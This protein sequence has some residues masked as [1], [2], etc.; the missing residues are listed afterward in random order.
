MEVVLLVII[1]AIAIYLVWPDSMVDDVQPEETQVEYPMEDAFGKMTKA[2]IEEW[3]RANL[4][5]EL[6]RRHTK[7]KMITAVMAEISRRI[8]G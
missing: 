7:A 2:E 3:A 1:A 8:A 5:L 4:G 6:D